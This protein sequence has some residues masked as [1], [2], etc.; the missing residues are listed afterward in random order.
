MVNTKILLSVVIVLLIG[1]AAATYHV[2]TTTPGLWQPTTSQDTQQSSDQGT[3]TQSDGSQ[4]QTQSGTTSGSQGVNSNSNGGSSVKI[5]TSEAKSIV[6]NK[7]IEQEGAKA[8]TPKLT[9]MNGKKVYVVPVIY[10][11]EQSGEIWIDAQT[12]DN[13]GGAGGAP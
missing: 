8:G 7:Y 5:S 1:V 11:G 2:T 13:I 3:T 6:Q 4:T 9:T 12:G 10:N